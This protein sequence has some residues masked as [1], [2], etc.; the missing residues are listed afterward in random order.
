MELKRTNSYNNSSSPIAFDL[1]R[2]PCKL[3]EACEAS[4]EGV[5]IEVKT[6]WKKSTIRFSRAEGSIQKKLKSENKL[7]NDYST[8]VLLQK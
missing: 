3:D 5:T 8:P 6:S 1:A 2:Q 4:G 7:E